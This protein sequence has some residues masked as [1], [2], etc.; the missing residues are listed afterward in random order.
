MNITVNEFLGMALDNNF[1]FVI[2]DFA[3]NESIF[4]GTDIYDI[5]DI[6]GELHVESWDIAN[7]KIELNVD[8]Y[9]LKWM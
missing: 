4:E 9:R 1:E 8:Q 2:Y 5:P 7:G 3:I 6:I